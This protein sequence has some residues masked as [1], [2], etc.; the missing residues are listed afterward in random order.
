MQL[1]KRIISNL[2]S[3]Y[4]KNHL[5]YWLDFRGKSAFPEVIYI[6][7]NN[8]CN[9]RC[10]MCD[11]GQR[12]L[13]SSFYKDLRGVGTIDFQ[14]W[15]KFIDEVKTFKPSI[16]INGTEPLLYPK[17]FEFVKYAKENDLECVFTTNGKILP[18]LA[19][20]IVESQVD[21]VFISLDA[22]ARIHNQIRGVENTFEDAISGVKKILE[23]KKE[24]KV[25]K[26]KIYISTTVSD[27]SY[28]YLYE[29]TNYL[30]Q[31]PVNH[32]FIGA[33]SWKTEKAAAKQN[34][35]YPEYSATPESITAVSPSSINIDK[36]WEEIEE[37]KKN[38]SSDFVSFHPDLS[39]KD[40][41]IFYHQPEIFPK[42]LR[43]KCNV[44]WFSSQI[45]SNGDVICTDRCFRY[46]FGNIAQESFLDIWN[47][48]RYRAFRRQ[49]K[50]IK[51]FPVCARCGGLF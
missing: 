3:G 6:N 5:S 22:P 38:F 9:M 11:V 43:K 27:Y 20:Q 36:L 21:G 16:R 18:Q 32:V 12:V 15:K 48:K 19:Q 13:N 49:L 28:P 39:K 7:I 17:L 26:P 31:V 30:S 4:Y 41:Q 40:W 44:A 25:D 50:K 51:T 37:I 47:N 45:L 14:Y 46:V 1:L 33:L 24:K 35:K 23:L 10:K 8:V 34:E 2:K 29:L 42:G